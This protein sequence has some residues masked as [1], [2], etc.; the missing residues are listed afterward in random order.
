MDFELKIK[1]LKMHCPADFAVYVTTP[2]EEPE[3][4][5]RTSL[6]RRGTRSAKLAIRSKNSTRHGLAKTAN[7]LFLDVCEMYSS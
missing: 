3:L 7:P 6:I 2:Q 4:V 1:L 5:R